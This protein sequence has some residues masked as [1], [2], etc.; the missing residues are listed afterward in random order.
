MDDEELRLPLEVKEPGRMARTEQTWLAARRLA[1]LRQE[2]E[3]RRGFP[4][5]LTCWEC[6]RS[7]AARRRRTRYCSSPC[8]QR[9]YRGRRSSRDGAGPNVP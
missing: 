8:R 6:R 5:I 4:P 2:L 9:A 3:V 1:E 7:F